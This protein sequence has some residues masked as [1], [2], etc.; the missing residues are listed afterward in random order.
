[1][2]VIS[3]T[4][5]FELHGSTDIHNLYPREYIW[6]FFVNLTDDMK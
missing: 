6:I 4:A 5:I 3:N 1:M 2:K